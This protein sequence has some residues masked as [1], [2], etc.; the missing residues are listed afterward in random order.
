MALIILVILL[1]L[2]NEKG[3][4]QFGVQ[5]NNIIIPYNRPNHKGTNGSVP[6]G[7]LLVSC[8]DV[9]PCPLWCDGRR[10]EGMDGTILLALLAI[11]IIIL[12]LN[13]KGHR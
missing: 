8:L 12:S 7:S 11:M 13:E 6:N 3:H 9:Q 5:P 10:F 1:L 2:G 4:R